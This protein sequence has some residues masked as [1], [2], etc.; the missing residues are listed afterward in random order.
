MACSL[1]G[2][3]YAWH[4]SPCCSYEWN[5]LTDAQVSLGY[6]NDNLNWSVA[7]PSGTPDVLAKVK[8]DN[9]QIIQTKAQAHLHL[10]N[11]FYIRG[12]A[13]YGWIVD[14]HNR[15]ANY[16]GDGET[17]EF[18]HTKGLANKGEVFDFSGGI[19]W[20]LN[21]CICQSTLRFFPMI[22]YSYSEQHLTDHNGEFLANTGFS[23]IGSEIPLAALG[24]IDGLHGNYRA[25]W[26][27]A[28]VGFDAFMPIGCNIE[29]FGTFEY[30]R[31]KYH[32]T[33]HW[34]LRTDF[35]ADID[36]KAKKGYGYV[37][38]GG[39]KY[40]LC[41]NVFTGLTGS[42]YRMD[43]HR[44]SDT[45]FFAAGLTETRLNKVVW[46]SWSIMCDIGVYY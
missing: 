44:G 26:R 4:N 25:K 8:W 20:Q 29:L 24:P 28:W 34:N 41:E 39:L 30:H 5:L 35:T 27:G 19:G 46:E 21:F 16:A 15:D 36:Q 22:G 32:G 45:T 14:G 10:L 38:S 9:L 1:S 23:T 12:S 13:D 11:L 17:L 42:Y 18:Y 6:R 7:D 37:A 3:V 31:L 2:S 33:V 43:S 40:T